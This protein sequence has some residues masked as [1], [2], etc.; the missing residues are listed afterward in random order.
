MIELTLLTK[1]G[2]HLCDE[3]KAMIKRC[4]LTHTVSIKEINIATRPDLEQRFGAE[5]P[6]LLRGTTVVARQRISETQLIAAA[7]SQTI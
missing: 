7:T 6:V 4:Q 5:I 3:L 1:D 2:C